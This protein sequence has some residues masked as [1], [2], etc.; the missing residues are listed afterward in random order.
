[1]G[2]FLT[3]GALG[4]LEPISRA[5]SGALPSDQREIPIYHITGRFST[6]PTIGGFSQFHCNDKPNQ[7]L[8]F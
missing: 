7:P 4:D 8:L 2:K 6:H 1:M 3:G 5:L